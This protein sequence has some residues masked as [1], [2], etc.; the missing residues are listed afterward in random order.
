MVPDRFCSPT[1]PFFGMVDSISYWLRHARSRQHCRPCTSLGYSGGILATLAASDSRYQQVAIAA[2]YI[3]PPTFQCFD[4]L[5][6]LPTPYRC[7]TGLT[8]AY[9]S[10][11][12]RYRYSR[13]LSNI[14]NA[15]IDFQHLWQCS[16][17]TRLA[18]VD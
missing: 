14:T 7:I 10:M 1:T 6:T 9:R 18:S 5:T 3:L 11:L 8:K 4:T 13:Q 12:T 15:L 2:M 16:L 17:L